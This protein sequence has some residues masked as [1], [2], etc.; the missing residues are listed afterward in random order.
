MARI[1]PITVRT[2]EQIAGD[3][4]VRPVVPSSGDDVSCS[5]PF[6]CPVN[7]RKAIVPVFFN[8]TDGEME[9]MGT[10]FHVD[11]WGNLITAHHVIERA[12]G[13]LKLPERKLDDLAE[14]LSRHP[15]QA[16]ESEAGLLV[17]LGTGLVACG[18]PTTPLPSNAIAAVEF[19]NTP[20]IPKDD[21][22]AALADKREMHHI[23]I[24]HLKTHI[25]PPS[26]YRA[27]LPIR[28]SGW[29]PKVGDVVLAIGYPN[30]VSKTVSPERIRL[31]E[32]MEAAYGR[33]LDAYPTGRYSSLPSMSVLVDAD[34]K[35]GMSG[36]PVLNSEGEV[37]G[38]VSRGGR[39]EL[40]RYSSAVCFEL[41]P[42]IQKLLP[43]VDHVNPTPRKG[44]AVIETDS[45]KIIA[46]AEYEE[47][48]KSIAIAHL[49]PVTVRRA[50]H[51]LG[52]D[53]Y[54]YS[55]NSD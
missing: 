8:Y 50:S 34:W 32:Q 19:T 35:H 46:F 45:K 31:G 16:K 53:M 17:W 4:Q 54:S 21:P 47:Q 25:P 38:I 44:W 37:I 15:S 48:A 24:T 7:L 10:A 39:D 29:M 3:M 6:S 11:Y 23:D 27:T 49:T 18:A 14:P 13:N 40:A 5:F 12:P 22:I 20:G 33:I 52:R 2:C 9:G 28:L 51:C 41:I 36:G 43:T 26:T 30:R 1:H 55:S 42:N